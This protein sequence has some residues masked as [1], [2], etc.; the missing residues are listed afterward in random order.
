MASQGSSSNPVIKR[1]GCM[2]LCCCYLA[3]IHDIGTCEQA[4]NICVNNGWV[5]PS[6]SY[7]E[8]SRYALANNLNDIYKKGIKTGLRFQ[9][10]NGHWCLYRGQNLVYRP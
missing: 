6:N 10:D 3:N 4:W 9:N 8:V 1:S 2:F 7:C 5:N